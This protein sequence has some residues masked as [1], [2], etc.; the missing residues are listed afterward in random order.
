[1]Y[2]VFYLYMPLTTM[3]I[4]VCYV[5]IYLCMLYVYIYVCYICIYFC[6]M[7]PA[8]A[9]LF[10]LSSELSSVLLPFFFLFVPLFWHY[11]YLPAFYFAFPFFSGVRIFRP[12]SMLFGTSQMC[13]RFL[14][15]FFCQ[16]FSLQYN[17]E[18]SSQ[19]LRHLHFLCHIS[20]RKI[21][22]Q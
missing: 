19:F 2:A 8:G 17:R 22:S 13:F 7:A 9:C 6:G 20:Q 21:F 4:Y 16:H 3:Y 18:S 12:L 14:L 5:Y 15:G 11:L 1:M 10:G